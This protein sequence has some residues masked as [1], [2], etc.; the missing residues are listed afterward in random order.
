MKRAVG[1]EAIILYKLIK[2]AAE[3]LLFFFALYLLVRAAPWGGQPLARAA[4]RPAGVRAPVADRDT[5][6]LRFGRRT[7]PA[8][9]S[10]LECPRVRVRGRRP[11]GDLVRGPP[12]RGDGRHVRRGQ[13]GATASC[14]NALVSLSRIVQ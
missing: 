1:L 2:A 5:C 3:L 9:N 14:T 10:R 6:W 8:A 4:R 12:S 11:Q 13:H 7:V